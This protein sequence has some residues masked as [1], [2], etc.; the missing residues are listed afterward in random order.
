MKILDAIALAKAGYK[1]ADI[2]KMLADDNQE[3]EKQPEPEPTPEPDDSTHDDDSLDLP[4]AGESG[5]GGTEPDYKS[6]YEETQKD[7]KSLRDQIKKLQQDKINKD[8][9]NNNKPETSLEDV[10]RAY[11]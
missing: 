5:E 8:N 1:K 11:M 10:F 2:D 3:P 9:S 4:D 6:L 7:I